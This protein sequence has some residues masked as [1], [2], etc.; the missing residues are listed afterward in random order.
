[1]SS[2]RQLWASFGPCHSQRFTRTR[3][4]ARLRR[5]DGLPTSC[6]RT[7]DG[8]NPFRTTLLPWDAIVGIYVGEL[9]HSVGF[10]T[11]AAIGVLFGC[12]AR[13]I[14]GP[15]LPGGLLIYKGIPSIS[16]KRTPM[17]AAFYGFRNYPPYHSPSQSS[18]TRCN[19][20]PSLGTWPLPTRRGATLASRRW[21]PP[22]LALFLARL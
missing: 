16:P 12:F 2:G 14:D 7:V 9:N 20:K 19:P 15:G 13:I 3:S 8:R 21:I 18:G 5:A 11:G 22:I 4:A 17:G 10:L 6:P 1:M